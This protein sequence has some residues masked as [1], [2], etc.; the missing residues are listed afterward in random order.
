MYSL[1][2]KINQ[3]FIAGYNG[4]NVDNCD[5][6]KELLKDG[7]GGAI[8]FTKNIKSAEQFGKTTEKI[9]ELSLIP[10]FLSIDQEGGRVERTENIHGGKKYLSAKDSADKGLDF[11]KEQTSELC[12]ELLSYGINMNFAPVLD[13]NTNPKNPIIGVRSY[14]DN[15]DDVIK[16]GTEVFKIHQEKG[17]MPVG[18][19]F[20]GHGDTSVDSHLEMPVVDLSEEEMAK[21][22]LKPFKYAVDS[23]LDFMMIAHVYYPCYDKKPV[24]ASLSKNVIRHLLREKLGFDGLVLSD[25]MV[26]GAVLHKD[27][28]EVYTQGLMAGINVFLYRNSDARLKQILN[29]LEENA[30]KNEELLNEIEK[31]FEK[32]LELKRKYKLV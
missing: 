32:V 11:V 2:Q 8:F 13:T 24:P 25:D 14:G 12:N 18:K 7:L 30:K 28:S 4:D 15:P 29:C 6:F 16:F 22:H 5:T 17:I 20:P 21:S 9:R 27:I 23:G 26:M 19:H 10:P 3:L 1:R 31:S